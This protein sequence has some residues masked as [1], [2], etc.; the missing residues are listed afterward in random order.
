VVGAARKRGRCVET[1][2]KNLLQADVPD[3]DVSWIGHA[4]LRANP[5][6]VK[7]MGEI[8]ITG[9]RPA[10]AHGSANFGSALVILCECTP[11]VFCYNPPGLFIRRNLHMQSRTYAWLDDVDLR[12]ND[13]AEDGD[14][15]GDEELDEDDDDFDDDDFDDDDDLDEELDDDDLDDLD[16]DDLDD[17]DEEEASEDD[18]DDE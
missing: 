9:A 10:V 18:D 1:G 15:E 11:K 14:A 4:D 7:G 3:I 17:D 13:A 16:E 6:G 2:W 5:I 8:G 12:R